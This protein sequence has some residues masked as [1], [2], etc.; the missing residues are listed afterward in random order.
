MVYWKIDSYLTVRVLIN[1]LYH[2]IH[3]EPI[4][5]FQTLSQ[6]VFM[7][8]FIFVNFPW[9]LFLTI[10]QVYQVTCLAMTTNERINVARYKHF[11]T[12]QPYSVYCIEWCHGTCV[13]ADQDCTGLL[14]TGA[15]G[16]TWWTSLGG[17]LVGPDL[18]WSIGKRS[19]GWKMRRRG[20]WWILWMF[21]NTP[22]AVYK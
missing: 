17:T 14:S 7:T 4:N 6:V 22:F 18:R 20:V 2:I 21:R 5:E 13:Q 12:G 9:N 10:C 19:G 3:P 16:I 11:Q 1:I 8:I 15:G